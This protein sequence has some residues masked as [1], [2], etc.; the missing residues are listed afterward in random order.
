MENVKD[1]IDKNDEAFIVFDD[2][3]LDKRFLREIEV[4][5]RQYSGNEHKVITGI[6]IVSCIYVNPKTG[7][8]W[9]IDYRVFNPE[10]DGL[11]KINHV[12]EMLLSLVKQKLLPFKTV[13][14]DTWY[15]TNSLMLFIDDL[16]KIFYCPLKKNRLVDDSNGQDKYKPLESLIWSESDLKSGKTIKIKNFPVSKKV[17]LFRVAVSI[18]RTDYVATND[19]YQSD[20]EVVQQV[21][22]N[23]WKIEELPFGK[24]SPT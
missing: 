7:Q 16:S 23:R 13:L 6:G 4:A 19:L 21:C 8:F 20:T 17:K 11:T 18:D 15:A 9:V 3:V 24:A 14:M 5:R 1:L 12:K 10:E 2:S 22:K